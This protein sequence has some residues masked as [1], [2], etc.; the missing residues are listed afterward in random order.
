[1]DLMLDLSSF[2]SAKETLDSL[3]GGK[4]KVIQER[5]GYRF[6]LD[7]LLLAGFIWMRKGERVIDLGTGVGIIPLILGT[8]GEG[9]E[10]IVGVEIQDKLAGLAKRNALLN[11]LEDLITIYQRDIIGLN[12]VFPP[13]SFDVV[14]TNPPYYRV[15]SGRINPLS[16]KAIAR[17]EVTCTMDDLLQVARYLLKEG[18]RIFAI[19]PAHRSVTLLSLLRDAT[20]EPKKLRWVYSR[21]GEEA[22]FI[23]A[24]AHKGGREGVEVLPPLFIYSDKGKHTLEIEK[25]YSDATLARKGEYR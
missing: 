12:D 13:N 22:K 19:F 10:E 7:A 5:D 11:R 4:I 6:S 1:M 16:Q 17:H 9:V 25:L 14:V 23:L 18:G 2:S 20:L 15:S 3:F 8:R 24:E 21:E